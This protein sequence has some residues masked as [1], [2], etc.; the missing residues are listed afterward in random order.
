[1]KKTIKVTTLTLALTLAM[2][3]LFSTNAFAAAK[4]SIQKRADKQT[5]AL[6]NYGDFYGWTPT[7]RVTNNT[8]SKV[9]KR[10]TLRN[11]KYVF[12]ITQTTKKSGSSIA[13]TFKVHGSK[14]SLNGIK[15]SLKKYAVKAD[16]KSRLEDRAGLKAD[17]LM[18]KASKNQWTVTQATS[19]YKG[20]VAAVEQL[21]VNSK[22]QFKMTVSAVRKGGKIVLSYTRNGKACK[23]ADIEDWLVNYKAEPL[24][25]AK[26]GNSSATQ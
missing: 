2:T 25:G 11:S 3:W 8:V 5:A 6:T 9:V 12:D 19:I 4:S 18:R 13:T 20:G 21:V 7:V 17:E 10:I 16:F 14:Y 15:L 22:Y 23:A 26:V 1:M 24:S